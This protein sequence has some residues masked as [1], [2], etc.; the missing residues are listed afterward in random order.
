MD[1]TPSFC[2][3]QRTGRGDEGEK[4]FVRLQKLI[5][6]V[7]LASLLYLANLL[8]GCTTDETP[9]VYYGPPPADW[10]NGGADVIDSSD[11]PPADSGNGE[12]VVYY[13][14]APIDAA[15]DTVPADAGQATD[16]PMVFYGPAVPD[17]G[18]VD[19]ATDAVPADIDQ[20]A[21]TPMVYY[22]PPPTDL[23]PADPGQVADADC[24]PVTV[25]GPQPC[26][27]DEECVERNSEGWYC[28]KDHSYSDGCGGEISWPVCTPEGS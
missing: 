16:T 28:D 23:G 20:L 1:R 11:L 15:T 10:D 3:P 18:G 17:G 4:L 6:L 25:Y 12:P 8:V 27:T 24:P 26:D 5:A 9:S 14:P 22:G 13:G 7:A 21:D 19:A 2:E